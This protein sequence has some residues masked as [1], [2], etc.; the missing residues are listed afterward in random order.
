MIASSVANDIMN[1]SGFQ[2]AWARLSAA[3]REVQ[4]LGP[5][6]ET[7]TVARLSR[8]RALVA[9]LKAPKPS[10]SVTWEPRHHRSTREGSLNKSK[11]RA[12]LRPTSRV[13]FFGGVARH[14]P[15]NSLT[16][17][18]AIRAAID[19][20]RPLWITV[21]SFLFRHSVDVD[22]FTAHIN[23]HFC[24]EPF[25]LQTDQRGRIIH[26]PHAPVRFF[27]EDKRLRLPLRMTNCSAAASA[28]A[29]AIGVSRSVVLGT[30]SLIA[31]ATDPGLTRGTSGDDSCGECKYERGNESPEAPHKSTSVL[32]IEPNAV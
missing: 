16:T 13:V 14:S 32:R 18:G 30:A 25:S 15:F 26:A 12:P 21:F 23:P 5:S 10:T 29:N 31:Y 6:G 8:A 2:H 17:I 28:L 22:G 7:S 24:S 27:D 19:R 3:E 20:F 11:S 9:I 4:Q 1:A